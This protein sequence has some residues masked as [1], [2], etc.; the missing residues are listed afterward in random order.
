MDQLKEH[1]QIVE[2]LD[3]LDKNGLMKE[4]NEVQSLVSYI[5]GM[6]ETLTE[7]L[8]EL[9]DMRREINLIHNN[10]LRSKCHTLV[11]KTEG[12]I[13][14]GIFRSQKDEGQSDPVSRERCAGVPGKRQGRPRR[15]GQGNENPRSAG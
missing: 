14:Q 13:R 12:K 6:E 4:K 1:P 15:I 3:T 8:G 5:G 9:Q 11:E 10:T 7:M 2:L